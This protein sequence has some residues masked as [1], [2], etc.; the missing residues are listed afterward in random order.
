[1]A[2]KASES[3]L[4]NLKGI[5]SHVGSQIFNKE[6]ILDNLNLLIEISTQLTKQGHKL[7][8][9]DLGVDLE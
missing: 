8:Y 2:R 1:M 7:R 4:I 3:G 5:A 6:L 9:I